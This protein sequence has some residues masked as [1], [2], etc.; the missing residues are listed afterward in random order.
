MQNKTKKL[1]EI[2]VFNNLIHYTLLFSDH[3]SNSL[4]FPFDSPYEI[5]YIGFLRIPVGSS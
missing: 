3:P 5:L 4:I 2:I 1:M